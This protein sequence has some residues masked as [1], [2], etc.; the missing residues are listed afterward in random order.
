MKRIVSLIALSWFVLSAASS[1]QQQSSITGLVSQAQTGEPLAGVHVYICEPDGKTI[2]TGDYTGSDGTY[3]LQGIMPGTYDLTTSYVGCKPSTRTVTVAGSSKSTLDIAMSETIFTLGETVVSASRR[4]E[5]LVEAPSA[6]SV[7]PARE[8]AQSNALS[9]VEHLRGVQGVD[10]QQK[11]VMSHEYAARGFNG[12]FNGTVRTLTDNR[13]TNLPSL[14]ANVGYLQS[15]TNHDIERIEMVLGPGSALYGPNVT[16]GVMH[17]ITK[18]PF[19]SKGTDVSIM[20]GTQSL[21]GASARNAGVLGDKFAYKISAQYTTAEDWKY[22]ETNDDYPEDLKTERYTVDARVDYIL[23]KDGLLTLNGG[24]STA[25]RAFDLTD[26]GAAMAKD[27]RYTYVQGKFSLGDFFAQAYVNMNDAGE[28]VLLGDDHAVVEPLERIVD[29]SQKI[30]AEVQHNSEVTDYQKFV[31]GIDMHL[32]RPETEGT[33]MGINEDI[34]NVDEFGGYLQSETKLPGGFATLLLAGRIDKHSELEDAF[35]SPRIGLNL[36]PIENQNFRAT[37]NR[38]FMTPTISELFLDILY[39]DNVFDAPVQPL[40]Y[41][42]RNRGVPSTG[43]NFERLGDD[44]VFHSLMAPEAGGIPLSQVAN[45][46]QGPVQ[47]VAAELPEQLAEL[48]INMPAPTA[49]Q[50]GGSLMMLNL[51]TGSFDALELSEVQDI[52]RL[53]PTTLESYEIGYSGAVTDDIQLGSSLYY[54]EYKNF[55]TAGRVATP[56]VF[57]NG[58][59][60]YA[61]VYDYALQLLPE[62]QA[63]QFAQAVAQ[64]MASVPLGTVSPEEANDRTELLLAPVNFGTIEYWGADV[65]LRLNVTR[66][67]AL[68]STYSYIS[69]NYFDDVDG[70]GPLSL[71]VPKHKASLS[72]HYTEPSTAIRGSVRYRFNDGFQV[73]SGVYQGRIDP[74]GLVDVSVS[75]PIPVATRPVLNLNVNNLF[76]HQ[77]REYVGGSTIGRLITAGLNFHI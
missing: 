45:L 24:Q 58:D 60:T 34:D 64:G 29:N 66:D 16:N 15:V 28:T 53:E 33:I 2:I 56:N 77:H 20:G 19:A 65:S 44:L 52:P 25:S 74:Y 73:Q 70:K 37:F 5:K 12:V 31:Y 6:I 21:F 7:I 51:E 50:V 32:T 30:V 1:A 48:L 72:L 69:N 10:V 14:R 47:V 11:G 63:Q 27:F 13:M 36:S 18:S 68:G 76:D 39:T 71:N 38:A 23:G 8:I 46:W 67:L 54:S 40:T 17:T 57:L 59:E 41:G 62:E 22:E 26:N 9:T 75:A 35:I 43:L 61:Y 42:L 55:I 49:D 4:D 3:M